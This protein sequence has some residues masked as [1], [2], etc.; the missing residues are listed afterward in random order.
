MW[1]GNTEVV[2]RVSVINIP[3]EGVNAMQ[4]G[5]V[6][7]SYYVGLCQIPVSLS[8]IVPVPDPASIVVLAKIKLDRVFAKWA[9]LYHPVYHHP[10]QLA[11]DTKHSSVF[12]NHRVLFLSGLLLAKFSCSKS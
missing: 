10:Q 8:T 2:F 9:K 4:V 6:R 3:V 7:H 1:Y 5:T 11:N 12:P